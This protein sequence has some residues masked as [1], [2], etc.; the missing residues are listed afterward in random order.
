MPSPPRRQF[1]FTDFNVHQLTTPPPGDRLD[2]EFDRTNSGLGSVIDFLGK[3]LNTDGT[4][5]AQTVGRAQLV[6]GL[7]DHL[8]R[9]TQAVLEAQEA[10]A[11]AATGG[12]I[13]ARDAAADS[14]AAAAAS[15][16]QAGAAASAAATAE[17]SAHQ[18]AFDAQSAATIATAAA[19]DAS[20]D[21]NHAAGDAAL[22]EDWGIVSQAWAEHMPDPIPPNILAVMG[23][24]GDHWSSRWWANRAAMTFGAMS[25][26]Y[27]G[28]HDTPPTSTDTGE[29]I[30][31]GAIYYNTV[32]QQTYIWDGAEWQSL[33][34]PGKSVV[35]SLVYRATAGQTVFDTHTADL[36][37]NTFPMAATSPVEAYV[38]G[39]RAV[40]D[41]PAGTG[42]YLVNHAASTVTFGTGLLA[43]SMVQIDVMVPPSDLIAGT[44]T[45][46][47]LLAFDIDPATG[48]P[49]QIDGVRTSFPLLLAS[50]HSTVTV[51]RSAELAVIAGGSTQQPD[52]DFAASGSTI[53]FNEAPLPGTRIW[54]VWFHPGGVVSPAS[55]MRGTEA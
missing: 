53:T 42:D 46:Q 26:L 37:G 3:S 5:R 36:A 34:Q 10:A 19:G 31:V 20:N 12:A 51:T 17:A 29:P 25:D 33:T 41:M 48:N 39:V 7:F 30:L 4:L 27:L 32:T 2:S 49:G 8:T 24:T 43:G 11:K 1:S 13:V 15:A 52:V 38:N 54:A 50:D 47:M 40:P 28:A 16:A 6:P 45:T 35:A 9:E 23:V 18:S 44:V 22:A 55:L 14:A 21:A